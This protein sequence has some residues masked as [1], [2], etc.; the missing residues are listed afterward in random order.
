MRKY[1]KKYFK[2]RKGLLSRI[3]TNMNNRVK[4]KSTNTP[5]RYIGLPIISRQE[6][7]SWSMGSI[8]FEQLFLRWEKSKWKRWLVPTVDR[9]DGKQGYIFGNIVWLTLSD[10]CAKAGRSNKNNN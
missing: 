6:F 3:Y 7:Y 10:N 4:G 1:C 5:E 9:V 8:E 2:T